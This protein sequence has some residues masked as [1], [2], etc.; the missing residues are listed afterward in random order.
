[1]YST[2]E[3]AAKKTN[4]I[5]NKKLVASHNANQQQHGYSLKLNHFA[6]LSKKDFLSLMMPTI[7]MSVCFHR[8]YFFFIF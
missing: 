6:D 7:G 1:M 5:K 8:A 2:T 4:Y 3:L